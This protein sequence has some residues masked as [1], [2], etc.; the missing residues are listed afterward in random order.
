MLFSD[1]IAVVVRAIFDRQ[2]YG[3]DKYYWIVIPTCND[4]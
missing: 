4:S 1:D 2:G 3:R